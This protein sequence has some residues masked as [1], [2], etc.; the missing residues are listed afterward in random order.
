MRF[1]GEFAPP[2]HSVDDLPRWPRPC[3]RP[4]GPTGP[5]EHAPGDARRPPRPPARAARRVRGLSDPA[6]PACR[7]AG[8]SVDG[9]RS[10][11]PEPPI[12]CLAVTDTPATYRARRS[13]RPTCPAS[14]KAYDVRG[15]VGEQ[16]DARA[17]PRA[18]A[19]RWPGCCARSR[20]RPASSSS[21]TTCAT[22]RPSWRPRSPRA[23]PRRAS[24]SSTSAW[25]A[26]TCSTS[27][28]AP[29]TS[30]ARCSPPAT[31]RPATTGSSCAGRARRRSAQ[32]TG[33]A[34]IREAV[35]Q[36]VPA[37]APAPAPRH[38]QERDM[39][40]DYA[41]YLRGLVDLTGIRP[42]QGRRRRGQR[43]GRLHRA[44]GARAGCR[45]TSCRCTSSS[46]APSPTTRP[47]RWTRRTWSTCR[48]GSSPRAPTS[49]WPST[50]TP[51][52][53][54]SSTSAASR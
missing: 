42:L 34:T 1:E 50:A 20:R 40:A 16:I 47:T 35:E 38:R 13:P 21:A 53:A 27:P 41:A 54:S 3:A 25:P 28:P 31:T 29:S 30:P 5:V 19:P 15:V 52:A 48:S 4:G 14:I 37:P 45:W 26:P 18:S 32:D 33:L 43:H 2:Q 51:T 10:G 44:R 39:L 24:T 17:R 12:G 36:G 7:P 9:R 49:G 23:S 8:R 46:T 6:V 22:S 11:R